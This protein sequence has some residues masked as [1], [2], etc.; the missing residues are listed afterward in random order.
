MHN[1]KTLIVIPTYNESENIG[2]LSQRLVDLY[3][4]VDILV[5]DDNSPDGTAEVVRKLNNEK[6][7]LLVRT[8]GK[9]GRGGAV[10]AGFSWG[11]QKGYERFVEMDSDF[12]HRPED[13]K[14][15]LQLLTIQSSSQNPI[16]ILGSRY[17]ADSKIIGWPKSRRVFSA[18]SNKLAQTLI[19]RAASDFTNGFRIYNKK[20]IEIVLKTPQRHKGY[21]YLSEVLCELVRNKCEVYE[22]PITFENRTRGVSN[23]SLK[24][25]KDSF[26]GIFMIAL[27]HRLKQ[28]GLR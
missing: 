25:I 19:G 16:L 2:L 5:V 23:T 28:F 20:A 7:H 22:F 9:S 12:S 8:E 21:I 13:L 17:T 27:D 18:F 15:G 3:P 6:V 11:M 4:E 1:A 14:K 10:R 26:R 24:E